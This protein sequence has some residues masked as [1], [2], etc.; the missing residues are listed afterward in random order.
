MTLAWSMELCHPSHRM[1]IKTSLAYRDGEV[2]HALNCVI[3]FKQ[4]AFTIGL[5]VKCHLNS[6]YK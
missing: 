3:E 6:V 1:I 2:Q 5:Y 4:L